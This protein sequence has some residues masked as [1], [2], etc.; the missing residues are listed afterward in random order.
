M[1]P[2]FLESSING[3]RWRLRRREERGQIS[4]RLQSGR[5]HGQSVG[6]SHYCPGFIAFFVLVTGVR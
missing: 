2:V 5:G 1:T 3:A 6:S 4:R